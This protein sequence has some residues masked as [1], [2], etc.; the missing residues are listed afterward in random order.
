MRNEKE[1]ELHAISFAICNYPNRKPALW[2]Y[3]YLLGGTGLI[4]DEAVV[5]IFG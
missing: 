1:R 4:S 5:K 2:R 3:G